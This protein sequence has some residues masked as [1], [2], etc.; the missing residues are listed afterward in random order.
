MVVKANGELF[1]IQF[2]EEIDKNPSMVIGID[3]SKIREGTR[4]IVT[5]TYNRRFNKVYTDMKINKKNEENENEIKNKALIDLIKGALDFFKSSNSNLKPSTIII[6][7]KGGTERQVEKSIRFV[8]PDIL[9]IFSGK[10]DDNCY[11]EGYNPKLTIFSVNKRTELKFFE[12]NKNG[13]K[14][15]S[16]GSVID[17]KVIN[18]DVFEFYLQCPEVQ[19]GT[20]S[21]VHFLCIYNN[22]EDI[23]FEDFERITFYLSFY[24][25]NWTGPIRIPA[26][27]KYAELANSFNSKNLKN[28]VLKN[29][30]SSPYF[31]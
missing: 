23:T 17:Q 30:K 16:L 21:P 29:L 19:L 10:K 18:P 26:V 13:Y 1:K 31:I 2:C 28:E 25:W 20:A 15:I 27:L 6:Y 12:K 4:Y 3:Y 5:S 7:M 9:K 24:Y 11:E 8:L 22:N 14:N